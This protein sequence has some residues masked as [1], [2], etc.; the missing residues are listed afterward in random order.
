MAAASC[1]N[2]P[3]SAEAAAAASGQLGCLV[4]F[5]SLRKLFLILFIVDNLGKQ[6]LTLGFC[7]FSCQSRLGTQKKQSQ[8]GC[9]SHLCARFFPWPPRC[10]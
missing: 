1:F 5:P 10:K 7:C 3:K 9:F 4:F 8:A 6:P 2:T